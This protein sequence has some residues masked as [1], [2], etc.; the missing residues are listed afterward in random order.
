MLG[1]LKAS[2]H[3]LLEASIAARRS[4]ALTDEPK[5][6]NGISNASIFDFIIS[7]PI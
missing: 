1:V 7:S 4:S 5:S 6:T 3:C 2:N